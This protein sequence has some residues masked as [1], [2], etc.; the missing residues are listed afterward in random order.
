M[1]QRLMLGYP[2]SQT[3]C[4]VGTI[5]PI[6]LSGNAQELL[7]IDKQPLLPTGINTSGKGNISGSH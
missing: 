5:T 4:S 3:I 2:T 1:N 6:V 7:S